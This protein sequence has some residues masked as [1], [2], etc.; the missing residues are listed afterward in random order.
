MYCLISSSEIVEPFDSTTNATGTSPATSSFML[1]STSS[2]NYVL[3]EKSK[4]RKFRL[5]GKFRTH[6][7]TAASEIF[8]CTSSMASSSAGAT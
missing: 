5:Y 1:K 3:K 7:T 6:D 8:G 2:L 4:Q